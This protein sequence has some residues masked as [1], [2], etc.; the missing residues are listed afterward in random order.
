M[1]AYAKGYISGFAAVVLLMQAA[2]A[3]PYPVEYFAQPASVS[4]VT[5]SPDGERL[6]M[7][8]TLSRSSNPV[9]YIYDADNLDQASF[10]LNPPLAEIRSYRWANDNHIVLTLLRTERD[11]LVQHNPDSGENRLAILDVENEQLDDFEAASPVVENLFPADPRK[12]IISEKAGREKYP[13]IHAAFRPRIYYELDL[14]KGTKHLL[15]RGKL[16]RGQ[17]DFDSSGNPRI[18]RGFRRVSGEYVYYYR[19]ADKKTWRDM[20]RIKEDSLDLWHGEDVIAVDDMVPG[21]VLM[22]AHNGHDKQGLW[23]FNTNTKTFDELLY[24]RSDV[25]VY[26]IRNHSN[27]WAHPDKIIG[28][29]YFKD[30]F[31]FEY[32]DEIEGATYA[33]LEGLVEN[34]HYVRITSRSRDGETLVAENTGP[35]D[36]GTYYLYRNRAFKA[37]GSRQPLI[38]SAALA[39]VRYITYKARDGRKIPAFITVPNGK[40]PHPLIVMPHGGPDSREIVVYDERAQML[41]NNG[42]MVLQPQ[43]RMSLGYGKEHFLSAFTGGSDGASRMQQDKD[44]GA[45][46]LV[47]EGLADPERIAM[48]GWS[49]GGYAALLAASRS[50]QIYRCVIAGAAVV[51]YGGQADND[52]GIGDVWSTDY[53]SGVAN[54]TEEVGAVNVP[55]LLVHGSAD[56]RVRPFEAERYRQELTE[57]DKEHRYMELEGA[58]HAY[59]KL[60]FKHRVEFYESTLT[61]LKNDCGM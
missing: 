36:P 11:A 22:L 45:L 50:P 55:V 15:F 14:D 59:D 27:S 33:Q 61:F 60:S 39:D 38:D 53:R 37:V 24:R 58:G 4:N 10:V 16:D 3:E 18:G 29:S 23:T 56:Q 34:A 5:V 2:G 49:Y 30:K 48:F 8:K 19:D 17:I 52:K 12:I 47:E 28:V 1:R 31:R 7:L 57:H 46:H 54:L 41:A 20:Y 32:F 42:Y 25:D 26:G 9:L 13:G 35:R 21:N 43:F 44:D 40:G 6:A 51:D